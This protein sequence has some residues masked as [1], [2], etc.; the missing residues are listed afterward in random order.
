M[1]PYVFIKNKRVNLY[2]IKIKLKNIDNL[3]IGNEFKNI[4]YSILCVF[5]RINNRTQGKKTDFYSKFFYSAILFSVSFEKY[6]VIFH[7]T[8]T[9]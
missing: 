3:K 4:F 5:H 1:S 9:R 8:G 6:F 2:K 7:K